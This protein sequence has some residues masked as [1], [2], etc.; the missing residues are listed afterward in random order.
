MLRQWFGRALVMK[1]GLQENITQYHYNTSETTMWFT[2]IDWLNHRFG[3]P[4][5]LLSYFKKWGKTMWHILYFVPSGCLSF[6]LGR[7]ALLF[8]KWIYDVIKAC[9]FKTNNPVHHKIVKLTICLSAVFNCQEAEMVWIMLNYVTKWHYKEVFKWGRDVLI[10][11][12]C[13]Q[14]E[15][16]YMFV[17]YK[18]HLSCNSNQP[19]KQLLLI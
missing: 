8:F 2:I 6:S 5:K 4:N 19:D 15:R 17:W 7:S 13:L 9:S 18:L 12:S 10:I 14:D 16:Q 11:R 3:C 1:L